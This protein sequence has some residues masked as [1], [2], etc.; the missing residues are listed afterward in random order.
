MWQMVFAYV[1]IEG[2]IINPYVQCFFYCCVELL[3]FPLHY[4]KIICG[5][6][7]NSGVKKVIYWGRCLLMFFELPTNALEDSLI[8]SSSHSTLSHLYL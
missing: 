7:V 5:D 6:I 3:V 4:A 2:W 8:Y 1:S